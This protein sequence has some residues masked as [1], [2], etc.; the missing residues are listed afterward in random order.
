MHGPASRRLL[1]L[2]LGA[3]VAVTSASSHQTLGTPARPLHIRKWA[4][5]K[6][7]SASIRATGL[8]ILALSMVTSNPMTI[9]Q[10]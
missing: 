6:M 3:E 1:D 10:T 5:V 8:L 4:Q 7:G 9:T 2:A